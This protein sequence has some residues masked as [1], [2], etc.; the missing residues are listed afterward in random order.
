MCTFLDCESNGLF[1]VSSWLECTIEKLLGSACQTNIRPIFTVISLFRWKLGIFCLMGESR[2][3]SL[4]SLLPDRRGSS[5]G[6]H[7]DLVR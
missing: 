4:R 5:L 7:S 1:E 6:Y 3:M 2:F